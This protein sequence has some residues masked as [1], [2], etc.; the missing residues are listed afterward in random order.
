MKKKTKER[1]KG[2]EKKS[3]AVALWRYEHAVERR[4]RRRR[5]KKPHNTTHTHHS[6]PPL[7]PKGGGGFPLPCADRGREAKGREDSPGLVMGARWGKQL[8]PS[9]RVHRYRTT[10]CWG[11]PLAGPL[12]SLLCLS[13]LPSFW[14]TELLLL[15]VV[16]PTKIQIIKQMNEF[17]DYHWLIT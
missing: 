4:R 12:F 11:L 10:A 1:E 15:H 7:S 9:T 8:G 6:A 16:S 14:T 5:A 17:I 3:V 2:K 13:P